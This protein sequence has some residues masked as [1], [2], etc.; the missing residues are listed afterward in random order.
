MRNQFIELQG[1]LV[2]LRRHAEP[3]F[4][5]RRRGNPIEGR[6]IFNRI[7][8]LRMETQFIIAGDLWRIEQTQ[9]VLIVPTRSADIQLCLHG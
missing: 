9:P 4:V 2:M 1:K 8:M 3:G 5:G 6:V 7:E